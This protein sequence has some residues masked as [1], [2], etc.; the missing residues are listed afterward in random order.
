MRRPARLSVIANGRS[1]TSSWSLPRTSTACSGL[2]DAVG[3]SF[4]DGIRLKDSARKARYMHD[5]T[6]T[7]QSVT[8]LFTT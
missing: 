1:V 5:F 8:G 7:S 6:G 3:M 2:I 4:P